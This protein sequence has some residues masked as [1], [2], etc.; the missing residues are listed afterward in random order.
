MPFCQICKETFLSAQKQFVLI[1]T[2]SKSHLGSLHFLSSGNK[3]CCNLYCLKLPP[4]LCH[5]FL[6]VSSSCVFGWMSTFSQF[7][8]VLSVCMLFFLSYLS[9]ID[10]S[11]ELFVSKLFHCNLSVDSF[12]LA[13]CPVGKIENKKSFLIYSSRR[14]ILKYKHSSALMSW[15]QKDCIR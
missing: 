5:G 1:C 14:K 12:H 8:C 15:G 7:V 13:M 3:I 6:F 4:H 2:T 11:Q 9:C 10:I